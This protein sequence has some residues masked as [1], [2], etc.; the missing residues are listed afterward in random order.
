MLTACAESFTQ[1]IEELK[2]LIPSHYNE[3]SEHKL[4]GIPLAPQWDEYV[5]REQAG[6]VIF[7]A[8]REAGTLVGYLIS[9]V[10]TGMHYETCLTSNGDIFFVYPEQ[11]GKRGGIMLF[12][13]WEEESRRRGVKLMTA[14]I[15]VRHAK[16]ARRLLEMMEFF[17]AEIMFWKFLED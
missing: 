17:E 10:T 16:E 7:I 9:F 6:Q 1:N 15:K 3:V 11:R 2:R 14:G 12:K 4:R 13:A 5:R 8:L